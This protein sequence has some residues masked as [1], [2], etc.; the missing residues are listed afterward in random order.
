LVKKYL[1]ILL[2]HYIYQNKLIMASISLPPL[3]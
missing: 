2:R 1:K 3:L